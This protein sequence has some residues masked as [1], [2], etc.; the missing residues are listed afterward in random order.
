M[1]SIRFASVA[2]MIVLAGL[3]LSL[4]LFASGLFGDSG[5]D[6][7]ADIPEPQEREYPNLGSQLNRMVEEYESGVSALPAG[8]NSAAQAMGRDLAQQAPLQLDGAVAITVYVSGNVATVVGFMESVGGDPR[9]VGDDYIEAYAPV[10]ILGALSQRPGVDRVE[11][12]IPPEPDYGSVLSQGVAAHLVNAWH[13]RGV[14]GQGVKIGIIDSGFRD[15]RSIQGTELPTIIHARC[16]SSLGRYS[17][18]L[19]DCESVPE[20]TWEADP[21]CLPYRRGLASRPGHGTIVAETVLDMAPG[22]TLYIADPSSSGDLA[23]IVNWM[24]S[25]GVTVINMSL[26]WVYDGPG[27]GTSKYSSSA[28]RAVDRAVSRGALWVNSAGN[29]GQESWLSA[30]SDP[31]SD[32]KMSFSRTVNDEVMDIPLRPC[33]RYLIQLRWKDDWFGPDTDLD[34]HWYKEKRRGDIFQRRGAN[35]AKQPDTARGDRNQDTQLFRYR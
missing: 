19:A 29:S 11:A 21:S 2:S 3:A 26:S 6:Q 28:L 4:L 1:L 35:W 20:V 30:W 16:F 27:D 5:G 13:A 10:S 17:T 34:L 25:Q 23:S 8:D 12:I 31:D 18:N 22:A 32:G 9:N 14:T 24:T 15:I 33:T 7:A